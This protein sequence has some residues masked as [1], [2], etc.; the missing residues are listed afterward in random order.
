MIVRAPA[1]IN[2][3]LHVTAV[4]DDGMHE[5]D[6]AFAYVD[7]WDELHIRPSHRL[8]V[9]CSRPELAG[10][11]NLVYRVLRAFGDWVG[12][13]PAMD[14]YIEKHLPLEAGL[15]GGSS[16]AAS[17]LLAACRWMQMDIPRDALARFAA[18]FGADIPCF[19]FGRASRAQGI[20]DMLRPYADPLPAGCVLLAWPGAG[21]STPQVFHAFDALTGSRAGDT[22]R[23]VSRRLGDNDLETSA[24]AVCPGIGRLLQRLRE[25]ARI[26]WMS[27][28]GSTCVAL[29]DDQKRAREVAK[30]LSDD[31][32]CG[33][34]HVGSLLDRHPETIGA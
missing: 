23:P 18:P 28:S 7:V 24:V 3:F 1:K 26:A 22:M 11:N 12:C 15:G 34:S 14:V 5:L 2:L 10:E 19:L 32:L 30:A 29:F 25:S 6:T 17:A 21:A 27:G 4:R 16:D 13:E 8:R 33:W 9:G 31:G 20:G